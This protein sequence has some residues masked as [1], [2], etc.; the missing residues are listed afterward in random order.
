MLTFSPSTTSS[1]VT[2]SL[3]NRRWRS[4][5]LHYPQFWS[6]M[7][8]VGPHLLHANLVKLW[9]VRS[10]NRPLDLA[11]NQS[12]GL[13]APADHM[14][15]MNYLLHTFMKY[16]ARWRSINFNFHGPVALSHRLEHSVLFTS[17][18]LKHL[19]MLKAATIFESDAWL[20][21]PALPRMWASIVQNSPQLRTVCAGVP[22]LSASLSSFDCHS[23]LLSFSLVLRVLRDCPNLREIS[24]RL[25]PPVGPEEDAP[26]IVHRK[27]KVLRLHNSKPGKLV[28]AVIS[29]VTLPKL[30]ELDMTFDSGPELIRSLR[31]MIKRSDCRLLSIN[32]LPFDGVETETFKL[33]SLEQLEYLTSLVICRAHGDSLL[34][35]LTL[36]PPHKRNASAAKMNLPYLNN[37]EF[38]GL[39][40]S[41]G[42]LAEML[43]SRP[44]ANI[45][46]E[47]PWHFDEHPGSSKWVRWVFEHPSLK[48]KNP[49]GCVVTN[50]Q[51]AQ[52]WYSAGV[53]EDTSCPQ[54][55]CRA[56]RCR[57]ESK[58]SRRYSNAAR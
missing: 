17:T 34:E 47:T 5:V 39:T 24:A 31:C 40:A 44:R 2:L 22:V 8:V 9:L 38:I 1:P 23:S 26:P 3:V 46:I 58:S 33:L 10:G 20:T 35:W 42:I 56:P 45:V 55:G 6:S 13:F 51:K 18:N 57:Y 32:T 25:R 48:F 52:P 27:L 36:R 19:P 54:T 53:D 7:F 28:E 43:A 30:T 21:N 16:S 14:H 37:L 15:A 4:I 50:P 12:L 49:C 41:F 11:F 29:R